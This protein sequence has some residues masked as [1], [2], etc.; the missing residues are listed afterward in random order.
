MKKIK[1]WP[2]ALDRLFKCQASFFLKQFNLETK[3]ATKGKEIHKKI[4]LYLRGKGELTKEIK[5]YVD[6]LTSQ[7]F[8]SG[9]WVIE[10]KFKL[11]KFPE[12]SGAVDAYWWSEKRQMLN[13]VDF[14]TGRYRV[15]ADNNSQLLCYTMLI[16]A[17]L[18]IKP[19]GIINTIVQPAV[20]IY[21][22]Q[23]SLGQDEID[24]FLLKIN[25]ILKTYIIDKKPTAEEQYGDHCVFCPSAIYCKEYLR[26]TLK[27]LEL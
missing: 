1:I 8:A 14:K 12:V 21:P 4:E 19:K 5:P 9:K 13:V 2:S 25:G 7:E 23:V 24:N 22:N 6:Y 3:V 18:G 26:N 15:Y 27:G 16:L 11:P 20:S 17:N 10:T